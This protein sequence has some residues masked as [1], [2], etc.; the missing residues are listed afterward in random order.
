MSSKTDS[1]D[2][3]KGSPPNETKGRR[4]IPT[5]IPRSEKGKQKAGH[6]KASKGDLQWHN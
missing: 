4:G 6:D 5:E 1:I 2:I 3:G